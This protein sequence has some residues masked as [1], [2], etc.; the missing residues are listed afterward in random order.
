MPT[1]QTKDPWWAYPIVA[2][3]VIV[4]AIGLG[5][6]LYTENAHWFLLCIPILFIL[7]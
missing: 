3:L 5:M 7:S 1:E 6:G 2:S 4:P